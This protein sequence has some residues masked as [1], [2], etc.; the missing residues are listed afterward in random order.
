M[1]N[2]SDVFRTDYPQKEFEELW[3]NLPVKYH[4]YRWRLFEPV[5]RAKNLAM[6]KISAQEGLNSLGR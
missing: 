6:E 1:K 4:M 3:S 2:L 5:L